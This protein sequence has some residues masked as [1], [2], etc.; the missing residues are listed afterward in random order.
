[1]SPRPERLAPRTLDVPLRPGGEPATGTVV[2]ILIMFD[3]IALGGLYVLLDWLEAS[4]NLLYPCMGAGVVV[5][6][7]FTVVTAIRG[8]AGLV[9]VSVAEET[10]TLDWRSKTRVVKTERVLLSDIV[11]VVVSDS[12][13]SGPGG[14]VGFAI[15]MKNGEIDL[16]PGGLVASAEHYVS[17]CTRLAQFLGVPARMPTA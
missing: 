11:E 15:G 9:R 5:A 17:Q 1:M 3:V 16:L 6:G 13:L 2:A 8:S 7:V 14:G 10:V 12:P 4:T